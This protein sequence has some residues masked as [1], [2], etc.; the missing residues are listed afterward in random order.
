MSKSL[1][2]SAP[3]STNLEGSAVAGTTEGAASHQWAQGGGGRLK[4]S[5]EWSLD[6]TLSETF[7]A[8]IRSPPYPTRVP[9]HFESGAVGDGNSADGIP[10]IR[11][12]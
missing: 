7:L 5:K 6:R 8:A 12:L 3:E 11:R 1:D 9:P 10:R 2:F 4:E